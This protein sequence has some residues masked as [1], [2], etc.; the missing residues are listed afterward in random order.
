LTVGP[1][2]LRPRRRLVPILLATGDAADRSDEI[3]EWEDK[4]EEAIMDN[5]TTAIN[6]IVKKLE[7]LQGKNAGRWRSWPR[8]LRAPCAPFS[9]PLAVT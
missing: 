1:P 4:L 8:T 7:K 9:A 5:D 2:L 3:A 6:Q